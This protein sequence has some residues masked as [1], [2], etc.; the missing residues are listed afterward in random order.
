[1]QTELIIVIKIRRVRFINLNSEAFCI[2]TKYSLKWGNYCLIL[3]LIWPQRMHFWWE[4]YRRIV[5]N[6]IKAA[7]PEL[8]WMKAWIMRRN[9]RNRWT[10]KFKMIIKLRISKVSDLLLSR[11]KLF[12]FEIGFIVLWK[13]EV[14]RVV[15]HAKVVWLCSMERVMREGFEEILNLDTIKF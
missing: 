1:M 8:I 14:L 15:I 12:W 11:L 5:E 2:I 3:V 6:A 7:L 9:V 4:K 13:I 10:L